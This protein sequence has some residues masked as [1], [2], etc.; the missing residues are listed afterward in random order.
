MPHSRDQLKPQTIHSSRPVPKEND[1]RLKLDNFYELQLE[2]LWQAFEERPTIPLRDRMDNEL[3]FINQVESRQSLGGSH[4]PMYH[5]V[6]ARLPLE[7]RDGPL[8]VLIGGY[9]QQFAIFPGQLLF[10]V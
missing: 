7:C 3:I 10:G 8:H 9:R 2:I 1:P 6:L 4:T 5:D